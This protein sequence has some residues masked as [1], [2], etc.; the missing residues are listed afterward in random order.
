ME[1]TI[2]KFPLAPMP[3]GS[4]VATMPPGAKALTCGWNG[5]AFCVWAS[6]DPKPQ[7]HES[8][9]FWVAGTGHPL[10]RALEHGSRLLGR[11]EVNAPSGL[12]IFHVFDTGAWR[13]GREAFPGLQEVVDMRRG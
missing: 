1:R 10:P 4:Y 7:P 12:L 2:W 8:R 13:A 5:G 3:D 11:V 6:V 9:W